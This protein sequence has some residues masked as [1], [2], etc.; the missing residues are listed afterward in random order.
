MR[1][2]VNDEPFLVLKDIR[3]DFGEH[4]AVANLTLRVRRGEFVSILGP[5][6]CGKTTLLRII[7]GFFPSAGEIWLDGKRI[8][9]LPSHRRG[10]V[11]V[12][13]SYALFPHMSVFENVAFGLRRQRLPSTEIGTRVQE[14][15]SLVRLQGHEK[16]YPRELSGGQQQRVALA[17]AVVLRPKL[18]LLDEP[19]SN[20]DAKLRK[21]LRKEFL[22]I[23]RATG[24]TT[25]LVTHDLEE[26]FSLSDR[27]ALMQAGRIEQF[28]SPRE[29]FARPATEFV[30]E[31]IGHSNTVM[32]D[33]GSSQDGHFIDLGNSLKVRV[34][35]IAKPGTRQRFAIPGH[36]VGI[37]R[38]SA[39]GENC[40]RGRLTDVSY[41][42]S[43]LHCKVE[44]GSVS[45]SC[46]LP[47]RKENLDLV[48][49]ETV[50]ASWS[51]EDMIALPND[52][53]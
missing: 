51:S 46:E 5:S 22:S 39:D 26:A 53:G 48:E 31:F 50:F 8:D 52:A 17:R 7:A 6:G 49:G 20:L 47:A 10:A 33:V 42:G 36:L 21:T 28:E 41:L 4:V 38:Q 25:L 32:G 23:H 27:V 44:L 3:K 19:L 29:I 9:A 40:L 24:A 16:R 35:S 43:S 14:A 34:P 11:M 2:D 13:Q 15:L 30:S 12:F 45:I 18:L 1:P 37:S